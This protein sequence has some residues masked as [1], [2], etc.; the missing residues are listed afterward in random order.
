MG[1]PLDAG[2][3]VLELRPRQETLE[4]LFVRQAIGVAD[5]PELEARPS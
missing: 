1:R 4:E 2:I 3:H 5:D